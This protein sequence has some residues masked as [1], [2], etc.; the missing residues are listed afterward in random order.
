VEQRLRW[1]L[2]KDCEQG[3]TRRIAVSSCR[4]WQRQVTLYSLKGR[5]AWQESD[6]TNHR[7]FKAEDGITFSV[8]AISAETLPLIGCGQYPTP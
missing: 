2:L 5:F 6:A 4:T 3:L 1:V 8:W 7:E